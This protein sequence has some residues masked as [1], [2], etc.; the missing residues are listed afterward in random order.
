MLRIGK[1]ELEEGVRGHLERTRAFGPDA[2]GAIGR[3]MESIG[4]DAVEF[5]AM[6][7]ALKDMRDP[8]RVAETKTAAYAAGFVDAAVLMTRA[9]TIAAEERAHG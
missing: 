7:V 3:I 4:V 6:A 8:E 5:H 1:D 9:A 2:M